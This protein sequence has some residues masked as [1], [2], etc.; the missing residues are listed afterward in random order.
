M[1]LDENLNLMKVISEL[2][3]SEENEEDELQE[4]HQ[5]FDF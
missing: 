1:S 4:K 3:E 5:Y 2:R